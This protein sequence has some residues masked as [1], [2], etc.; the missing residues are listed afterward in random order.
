MARFAAHDVGRD[1]MF[2]LVGTG[3]GVAV[4]A[5]SASG[6]S[7]SPVVVHAGL[8]GTWHALQHD[9]SAAGQD[10][11]VPGQQN[12]PLSEADA[13]VVG[14]DQARALR[15]EQMPTR[16]AVEDVRRDLGGDQPRQVGTEGRGGAAAEAPQRAGTIGG[17]QNPGSLT[18]G[19]SS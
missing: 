11:A 12:A 19:A 9:G 13:A 14:P 6:A 15:D 1:G 3:L 10:E 4:L 2:N 5:E 7:L 18:N 17:R 16:R 8:F